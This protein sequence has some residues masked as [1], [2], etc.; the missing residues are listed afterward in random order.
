MALYFQRD[1]TLRVFPNKADGT[2]PSGSPAFDI[3]LLEGFS[4]SQTTNSSE[5]TLSEMESTVG[6]SRRG[7][8]M[9]ND[10]LAPVEWSFSTYLRPYVAENTANP[11]SGS[12][13]SW[14]NTYQSW[15]WKRHAG[16][17]VVTYKGNG[18]A[19]HQIP[20]NLSKSPGHP[21]TL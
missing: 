11:G 16:F 19:G 13:Y 14:G 8:K 6:N 15:M 18:V 21:R 1:A 2:F 17:D 7:R 9:F 20:H 12:T 4:F 10:S 3:P 5:V